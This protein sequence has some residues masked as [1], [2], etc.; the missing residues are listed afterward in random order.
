MR[1]GGTTRRFTIIGFFIV[2]LIICSAVLVWYLEALRTGTTHPIK[3]LADGVWWAIVTVTTV[4]YGDLVP[5]TP[6]GRV[7]GAALILV[8]FSLFSLF[9]GL[10]ASVMVEEKLKGARGLKPI[11]E[12]GHMVLCGWND[13]ALIMMQA[14][15]E[16]GIDEN[17]VL[18][19]NFASDF[20]TELEAKFT[21]LKLLF[22][23]GDYA[24]REV[25][26]RA[27]VANASQ[28]IVLADHSLP[29]HSADDRAVIVAGAVRYISKTV[30][31][32]VQLVNRESRSHLENVGVDNIVI[33][34]E[35]GGNLLAN[36]VVNHH[37][38][39]VMEN[40]MRSCAFRR[41]S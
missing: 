31:L 25:L 2:V 35:I 34:E 9:T 10:I 32:T 37:Y 13:S 24:L 8:G 1:P 12:R 4:G 30:P 39:S 22:V 21:S 7:V 17:V 26:Q 14:F 16:K 15:A 40:L 6:A 18:V 19:G 11:K 20:F 36:N 28:V 23:R 27:G 38:V 3:S 33:F 41:R 5:V 29:Q